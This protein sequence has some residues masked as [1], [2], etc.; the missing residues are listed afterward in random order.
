MQE[1]QRQNEQKNVLI[2][3]GMDKTLMLMVD[4]MLKGFVALP[5]GNNDLYFDVGKK[6]ITWIMFRG[7][8]RGVSW[9]VILS[10]YLDLACAVHAHKV[11]GKMPH[12]S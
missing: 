2:F 11:L 4:L 10:R 9:K 8:K 1:V 6:D 12:R 7:R 3:D 5:E